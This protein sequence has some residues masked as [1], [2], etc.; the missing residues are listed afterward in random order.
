[1]IVGNVNVTR[2]VDSGS[3]VATVVKVSAAVTVVLAVTV[4]TE[5]VTV[6]HVADAVCVAV[7]MIPEIVVEVV[8]V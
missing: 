7:V 8:V 3:W 5:G 6:P 4:T 2:S 1:M